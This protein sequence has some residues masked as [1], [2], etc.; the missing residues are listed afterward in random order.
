MEHL[1]VTS[2]YYHTR[3]DMLE[4]YLRWFISDKVTAEK[5]YL[6]FDGVA[7]G[8]FATTVEGWI[9]GLFTLVKGKGDE[10]LQLAIDQVKKNKPGNT[11][12]KLFCTGE[13]LRK[14]YSKKGF[15]VFSIDEWD[16]KRATSSWNSA[17]F[18]TPVIY[19]LRLKFWY[20]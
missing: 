4:K 1:E 15:E 6:V 2:V 16:D 10:L 7:I 19:Y 12:I 3:L 18:G 11:S 17:K 5:Y 20:G 13:H 9:V 8:G 14:W